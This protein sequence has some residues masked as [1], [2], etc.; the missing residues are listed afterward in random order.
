MSTVIG[1]AV[2]V[3]IP[4][5]LKMSGYIVSTVDRAREANVS[6]VTEDGDTVAKIIQN[7]KTT[8]SY[9]MV[10]VTGD[11]T[12]LDIGDDVTIDSVVYMLTGWSE[13]S[14]D[15]VQTVTLDVEKEDSMDYS[16]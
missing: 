14:S 8:I 1:Q 2:T 5:A 16:V 12:A 13:S 10:P 11:V 7:P 9:S 15:G 3:G 6:E 4:T